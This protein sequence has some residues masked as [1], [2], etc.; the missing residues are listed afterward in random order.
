M[1]EK[2]EC[3]L[4]RETEKIA[5]LFHIKHPAEDNDHTSRETAICP[6]GPLCLEV[7]K[8]GLS[9]GKAFISGENN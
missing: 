1:R 7:E 6:A 5:R 4:T 2:W 3:E 8:P 9:T